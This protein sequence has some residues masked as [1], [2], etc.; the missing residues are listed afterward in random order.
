MRAYHPVRQAAGDH[1]CSTEL[2]GI[3]E[4][5]GTKQTWFVGFV[6]EVVSP[7]TT[8]TGLRT[9]DSSASASWLLGL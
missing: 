1:T 5:L 8:K 2:S 3:V 4:V 6:F 9:Q 7:I